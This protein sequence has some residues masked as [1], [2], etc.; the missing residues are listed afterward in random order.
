MLAPLLSGG[1]V[2]VV[3]AEVALRPASLLALL[4][5][6]RGVGVNC[7]PS[8]WRMLLESL[9]PGD[10]TG[11]GSSVTAVIFGGDVLGEDLVRSTR[12]VLPRAQIWNLYGPTECTGNASGGQ[13]IAGSGVTIG[14]AVANTRLYVL[15]AKLRPVPVG[16]AGE[17]HIGG[18]CMARG[19]GRPAPTA[20]RFIPDPFSPDPGARLY[21]T[22]DRVRWRSD[23]ELE[24]LGRCD[25]QLKVHGVR[26]EPSEVAAALLGHP[27][28]QDVAVLS[29]DD[30]DGQ[31]ELVAYVVPRERQVP[32]DRELRRFLQDRV[33]APMIPTLFVALDALPLT[34][35]GKLDRKAL[36]ATACHIP[37]G[38]TYV[39]PRSPL[40]ASLA[41][42]WAD[43]FG[44]ERVGV[45]DDF[46]ELGGHSLLATRIVVRAAETVGFEFPLRA[47][48]E[49]PTVA[50]LAEWAQRRG[51]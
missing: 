10:V 5:T 45:H 11:L 28:L 19:Y 23:G 44:L 41:K 50:G 49:T 25:D 22:G 34:S 40:E 3:P 38:S 4:Q 37:D 39:A 17:L 30:R 46:Y 15:D 35:R 31:P 51:A 29:R 8:V 14:R 18:R 7:V 20:E 16:I 36:P 6:K 2:W 13:V 24:F 32:N 42:V 12:A 48:F 21:R 1:A 27:A 26:V 47:I 43:I 9:E 33:P